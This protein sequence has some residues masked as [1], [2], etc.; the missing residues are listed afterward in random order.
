MVTAMRN[1]NLTEVDWM[2]IIRYNAYLHYFISY[3]LNLHFKMSFCVFPFWH[4]ICIELF[5]FLKSLL[6]NNV[7]VTVHEWRRCSVPRQLSLLPG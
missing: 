1:S 7:P 6:A 3:H 5:F 2:C 4:G